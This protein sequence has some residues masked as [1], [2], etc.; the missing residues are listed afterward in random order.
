MELQP[1]NAIPYKLLWC[2]ISV[3]SWKLI[4]QTVFELESGNHTRTDRQ[5]D[6]QTYSERR[7]RQSN[8]QIGF[9]QPAQKGNSYFYFN[10]VGIK[11]S[12]LVGGKLA[13]KLDN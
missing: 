1:P 9:T 12:P 5:T 8:R 7:T 6:R 13:R 2:S 4:G 3:P 11:G 10:L